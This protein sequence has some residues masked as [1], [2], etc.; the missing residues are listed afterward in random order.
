MSVDAAMAAIADALQP[1]MPVGTQIVQGQ[2]NRVSQPPTP[3]VIM[4]FVNQ[5]QLSTTRITYSAT[6]GSY[7]MPARLDIQLDFYGNDA[8]NMMRIAQTMLRSIYGTT[9]F[10]EDIK[11]LYCDEGRQMPLITG[12]EQYEQ[13]W[14]LTLSMQY[15]SPVT[16]AQETFNTTGVVGITPADV[17]YQ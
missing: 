3:C 2:A 11:P 1:L 14:S 17:V 4:T 16:V 12:E 10:P 5:V 9:A 7:M 13:R 8:G 15:N 6:T